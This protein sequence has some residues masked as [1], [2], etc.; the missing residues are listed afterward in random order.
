MRMTLEQDARP[1]APDGFD[2]IVVGAGTAGLPVAIAAADRGARVLAIE[3]TGRIG[4]T[5]HRTG[6][7]ISAGGTRR[8]RERGIDDSPDAHFAEVLRISHG[9]ANHALTQLACDLAP[10]MADWLEDNG[11]AFDPAT[12]TIT[13]SHEPY[14]TPRTFWG[15]DPGGSILTVLE[16]LLAQHLASGAI[17]VWLD[18]PVTG[19]VVEGERVVGVEAGPHPLAPSPQGRGGTGREPSV[20]E[21]EVV[22]APAVVL[23]TGGFTANPD[24]FARLGGGHRPRSSGMPGSTGDGLRMAEALGAAIGGQGVFLP[25]IGG[26][27]DPDEPGVIYRD[28]NDKLPSFQLIPQ[29]RPPREIWVNDRGERFVKEDEPDIEIREDAVKANGLQFWVVFDEAALAED[30]RFRPGRS[31]N[32]ASGRPKGV[33]C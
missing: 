11:F 28:E 31:I 30:R 13:F 10:G 27:A 16:R 7:N 15:V 14:R 19:L 29:L 21:G 25:T 8:Q 26:F 2:L 9:S 32:C 12:P 23:T 20:H 18:T 3:K 6:G 24:L 4:G 17:T 1:G 22:R 33:R 5:L